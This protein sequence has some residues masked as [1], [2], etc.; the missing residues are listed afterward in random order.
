MNLKIWQTLLATA[1]ITCAGIAAAL[2]A[3]KGPVVL[4][5]TGK[6]VQKN[7]GEAADFDDDM[8]GRLPQKKMTVPTPWYP[9]PQTFEGPLLR[10]VLKAAGASGAKLDFKALND[11]T[12]TI[13]GED[14]DKY[15]VIVARRLNGKPMSIREKGPLFVMYP[16][17]TKPELR[18]GEFYRRCAWQLSQIVVE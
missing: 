11:Y 6:V 14:A 9:T 10:D 3:P 18:E 2:D 16:F 15:D 8:L 13:P 5:L 1:L 4:T 7:H 12:I 17:D